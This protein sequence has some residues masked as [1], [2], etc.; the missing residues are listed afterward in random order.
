MGTQFLVLPLNP[1]KFRFLVTNLTAWNVGALSPPPL[2]T[3]PPLSIGLRLLSTAAVMCSL[4]FLLCLC[5]TVFLFCSQKRSFS[6]WLKH[7]LCRRCGENNVW[8]YLNVFSLIEWLVWI[9]RPILEIFTV[10]RLRQLI[11]STSKGVLGNVSLMEKLHITSVVNCN[12]FKMTNRL[13]S[14]SRWLS[15]VYLVSTL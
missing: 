4:W 1:P 5:C 11:V 15:E 2:F 14:I 6:L 13:H 3:T 7:V 8:R 9:L 10:C 12:H